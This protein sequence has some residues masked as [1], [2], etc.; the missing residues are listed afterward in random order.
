MHTGLGWA[1]APPRSSPQAL[2]ADIWGN[3]RPRPGRVRFHHI[4]WKRQ[5]S[6]C[7]TQIVPGAFTDGETWEEHYTQM[8]TASAPCLLVDNEVL[9]RG[10]ANPSRNWVSTCS[11]ELCTRTGYEEVWKESSEN[12][13]VYR[14][15][16]I[17]W[18]G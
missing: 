9:H 8:T 1:L 3:D 4:L 11:I 17:C 6:L 5:G 2:H 13:G 18:S 14:M 16:P 7:N 15:L 12:D 10:A